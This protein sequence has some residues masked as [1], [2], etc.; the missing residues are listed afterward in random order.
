M[1]SGSLLYGTYTHNGR[2]LGFEYGPNSQLLFM[3][4]RW[5]INPQHQLSIIYKKLKWGMKP[6]DEIG[7]GFDFG[8]NPNESYN[9]ANPE[10]YY[11]IQILNKINAY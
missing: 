9:V 11:K 10:Y 8:S 6:E 1:S 3:E 2:C 7:D 5:W 4:N